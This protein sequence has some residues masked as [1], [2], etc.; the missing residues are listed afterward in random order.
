MKRLNSELD[1]A[2]TKIF[3]LEA[4][5]K[6]KLSVEQELRRQFQAELEKRDENDAFL[7][8]EIDRLRRSG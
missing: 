2:R 6:E 1:R 5:L 3:T 8:R 7:R 4:E